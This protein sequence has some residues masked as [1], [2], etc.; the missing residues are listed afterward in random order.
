MDKIDATPS[1]QN[2]PEYES[3]ILT[4][5]TKLGQNLNIDVESTSSLI[6]NERQLEKSISNFVKLGIIIASS[7]VLFGGTLYL[8]H[9]GTEPANYAYFRGE[10]SV[11]R[12]PKTV[13]E[14]ALTGDVISI[15]QLGILVI[16]ITPIA[17]VALSALIFWERRD[18][19]YVFFTLFVLTGL[20]YSFIG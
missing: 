14:S 4:E 2:P 1:Q 16:I 7:I 5:D 17:R 3:I 8:V 11:L 20:I 15:I 9:H 13:L 6:K 10:P 19:A 12:S 18:W